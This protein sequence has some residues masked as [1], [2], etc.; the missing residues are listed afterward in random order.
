MPRPLRSVL[1]TLL[2][3]G[4]FLAASSAAAIAEPRVHPFTADAWPDGGVKVMPTNGSVWTLPGPPGHVRVV[5]Q[6]PL[7]APPPSVGYAAGVIDTSGQVLAG[8][9]SESLLF[10]YP[11]DGTSLNLGPPIADPNGN[12]YALLTRSSST[13]LHSILGSSTAPGGASLGGPPSC[14]MPRL[15]PRDSSSIFAIW[16][17]AGALDIQAF[18][19]SGAAGPPV[20]IVPGANTSAW[21]GGTNGRGPVVVALNHYQPTYLEW[22]ATLQGVDAG[23]HLVWSISLPGVAVDDIVPDS[24]GGTFVIQEPTPY[25]TGSVT[26]TRVGAGGGLYPGWTT[27]GTEI[28]SANFSPP[29]APYAV[30]PDGLGGL[31]Y[32]LRTNNG[33]DVHRLLP[34]GSIASGWY[35]A[36]FPASVTNFQL[37]AD[38]FGGAVVAWS[39]TGNP[40]TGA[41]VY[42]QHIFADGSLARPTA[43]QLAIAPGDQ[44]V[45]SMRSD[46]AG[47]V[48]VCWTDTRDGTKQAYVGHRS[49]RPFGSQFAFATDANP[50]LVAR[51]VTLSVTVRAEATGTVDFFAGGAPIGTVAVD[52]GV[53]SLSY[54]PQQVGVRTLTARY[55]GDALY[56]PASDSIAVSVLDRVPTTVAITFSQDPGASVGTLTAIVTP[57]DA[58]GALTFTVPGSDPVTLSVAGG[59]ASL[60]V[61][62]PPSGSIA[63]VTVAYSGDSLRFPSSGQLP[64]VFAT[65]T[66]VGASAIG[67]YAGTLLRFTATIDP[68]PT[69]GTVEFALDGNPLPGAFPAAGGFARTAPD[70]LPVGAHYVQ[71][72]FSGAPFLLPSWSDYLDVNVLPLPAA[73]YLR[74]LVP[75]NG[76]VWSIGSSHMIGWDASSNPEPPTVSLYVSRTL[77]STW[78]PIALG[79]PN[80]GSY[81]WTVTGP[82]VADAAL[83][84]VTDPSGF[85]VE[86]ASDLPFTIGAA[87]GAVA[88]APPD[89]MLAAAYPNPSRGPTSVRFALPHPARVRLAVIDLQGRE[90]AVLADG[91][92][93]AGRYDAAWDGRGRSG[94]VPAGLYF[95]RLSAGGHAVITRVAVV[96]GR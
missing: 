36:H 74:V 65:T 62:V 33:Y 24:T 63:P 7:C 87:V 52:H 58:T 49:V 6:S 31:L 83:I 16:S 11:A 80:T 19:P 37:C 64:L 84:R 42:M 53:A 93:P 81:T 85:A 43:I 30:M 38:G 51:P 14:L 47:N 50:C 77:G 90:V 91:D 95:V 27:H 56:E 4:A 76:E 48:Y 8:N 32:V 1:R 41:D 73:P 28:I 72:S 39:A 57:G 61:H 20:Q 12:V 94:T 68:P 45:T 69:N 60:E 29:P 70:S 79:V 9:G 82:V 3:L 59:A 67:V 96:S 17:S 18:G 88:D 26:V 86:D 78:T 89:V 25:T 2:A 54:V 15:V 34:T 21:P 75:N 5:A 13:C 23:G 46:L 66:T 35:A 55:S 71:A 22:N 44:F 40:G 92:Y 10:C